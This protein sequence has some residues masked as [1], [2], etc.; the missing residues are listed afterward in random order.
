MSKLVSSGALAAA[1]QKQTM[2]ISASSS[3]APGPSPVAVTTVVSSTPS[4]VMSTIAQGER[5]FV[6]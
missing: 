2:V 5:V 6:W 1:N 4:V 3:A